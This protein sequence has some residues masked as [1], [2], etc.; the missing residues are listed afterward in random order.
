LK[1]F[2]LQLEIPYKLQVHEILNKTDVAGRPGN[3]QQHCYH[4]SRTVNQKLLLQLL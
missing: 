2:L 1:Y 3:D 4:H